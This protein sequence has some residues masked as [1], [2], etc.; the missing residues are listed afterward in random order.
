L[1]KPLNI[2]RNLSPSYSNNV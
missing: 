2:I 1:E